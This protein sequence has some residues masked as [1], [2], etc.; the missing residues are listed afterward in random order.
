MVQHYLKSIQPSCYPLWHLHTNH[1]PSSFHIVEAFACSPSWVTIPLVKRRY[2]NQRYICS[3]CPLRCCCCLRN[4]TTHSV[5]PDLQKTAWWIQNHFDNHV[6]KEQFNA[7]FQVVELW[8]EL[9]PDLNNILLNSCLHNLVGL[10]SFL[11]LKV[12]A[13]VIFVPLKVVRVALHSKEVAYCQH[14]WIIFPRHS[15]ILVCWHRITTQC[16]FQLT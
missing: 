12:V 7:W 14:S 16:I 1:H 11:A 13:S 5:W 9:Q 15:V 4:N 2:Y 8:L 3:S 10:I 6:V